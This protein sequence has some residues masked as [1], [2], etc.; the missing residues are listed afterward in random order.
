MKI[1][2]PKNRKELK[3]HLDDPLF[4]NSYYLMANTLLISVSGFIFWILAARFYSTEEVGIGAA[5]ISAMSLL[6]MFS[7]LGLDIGLIRYLPNETDKGEMINS[8][9]MLTALTAFL[10]S[11]IFLAGLN[12]WSPALMVIKE[13]AIFGL[14]FILFTVATALFQLQSNVF[15]AFRQAKYSFF[16]FIVTILKIGILP[17]LITLGA[18][19]IY[20]AN[21]F[22]SLL[23]VVIGNI[24]ILKVYP[25][26]KPIPAIKKRVVNDMLHYSFGNYIANIFGSLP[27]V[28]LPILVVNVLGAAMNAYFYVAWAISLML[29]TIPL[30]ISK[31]LLAEG[32]FSPEK[33]RKNVI[34]SL[35]FIV[36]LLI[37]AII[38]V[39][40]FGRYVLWLFGEEYA[41]NSL[42]LLLILSVASVPY[43]V[44]SVYAAVKRVQQEVM[45]VI[46]VHGFVAMFA[47]FGGYLLMQS[48]GLIGIGYA[49]LL[50]NGVVAGG[51]GLVAMKDRLKNI[52]KF[53]RVDN[54]RK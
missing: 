22:A 54:E 11:V 6:Y 25:S 53:E 34:K 47:I 50:G 7:L 18:F 48:M 28:I 17:L 37:P 35:K 41:R 20:A 32:S 39:F 8:C 33:F 38:G 19:G 21:G 2:I 52:C 26:Y 16:Q 49:W 44:I 24:F 46:G 45:P 10:L 15:V 30:A 14:A 3:E 29:M 27:T 4:K 40:V 12:I 5:I 51:V 36:V 13:N 23:A 1:A 31:S 43:A 42:E 9:L